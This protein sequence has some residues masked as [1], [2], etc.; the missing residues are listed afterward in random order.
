MIIDAGIFIIMVAVAFG[1]F[2]LSNLV[3]NG[4]IFKMLGAFIF[5]ALAIMMNAEYEVAYTHVVTGG[6]LGAPQN[7]LIYI[8]GDGDPDTASNGQWVGWLFLG[9][10]LTWAAFFFMDI[11]SSNKNY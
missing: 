9:L 5:F 1:S 2:V 8:I 10:G 3:R 7:T 11:M 4:Y 6:D